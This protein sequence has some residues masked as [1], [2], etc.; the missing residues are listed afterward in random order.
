M[1]LKSS[2]YC[3]NTSGCL[4]NN[5]I[6]LISKSSKSNELFL[7]KIKDINNKDEVKTASGFGNTTYKKVTDVMKKK[8]NDDVIK[9][10]LES[11]KVWIISYNTNILIFSTYHFR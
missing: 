2:W 7:K 8:Y 6:G 9:V 10:T 11:R 5:S 3:C 4:L 1:Y